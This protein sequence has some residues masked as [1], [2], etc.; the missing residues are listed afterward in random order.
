[1]SFALLNNQ[2]P[3]FSILHISSCSFADLNFHSIHPS[4]ADCLVSEQFSFYEY[5]RLN[6]QRNKKGWQERMTA[7]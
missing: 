5:I 7:K 4:M 1:V 2:P 3:F 6:V